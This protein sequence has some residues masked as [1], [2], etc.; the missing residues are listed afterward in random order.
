MYL[1][2]KTPSIIIPDFRTLGQNY[3]KTGYSKCAL[4][5]DALLQQHAFHT[6]SRQC[7]IRCIPAENITPPIQLHIHQLLRVLRLNPLH[8]H[9]KVNLNKLY[10]KTDEN[11]TYLIKTL[12]SSH[13]SSTVY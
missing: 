4:P 8:V 7:K 9:M 2:K 5:F 11:D 6:T 1:V 12:N 10:L 13:N 3:T